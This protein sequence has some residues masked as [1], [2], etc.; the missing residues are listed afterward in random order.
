MT[1]DLITANVQN[2]HKNGNKTEQDEHISLRDFELYIR[3][4]I[5]Q[6]GFYSHQVPSYDEFLDRGIPYILKS[7]FTISQLSIENKLRRTPEDNTIKTIGYTG[8]ITGI[9]INPYVRSAISRDGVEAVNPIEALTR[10]LTLKVALNI[11]MIFT[12]EATLTDGSKKIRTEEMKGLKIGALPIPVFSRYSMLHNC[13]GQLMIGQKWDP[14]DHGCQL[15]INGKEVVFNLSEESVFNDPNL[16]RNNYK[17]ELCRANILSRNG[18]SFENSAETI[19]RH[20]ENGIITIEISIS[21]REIHVPYYTIMRLLGVPTD[22]DIIDHVIQ[23]EPAQ[24]TEI[25]HS[26]VRALQICHE[27]ELSDKY[28]GLDKFRGVELCKTVDEITIFLT[29]LT[30]ILE[31]D[32]QATRYFTNGVMNHIDVWLLPHLGVDEDARPI[33]AVYIGYLVRRMLYAALDIL[34][35]DDR[36]NFKRKRFYACGT[37]MT[38]QFKNL[39][40]KCVVSPAR[41]DITKA[42]NTTSFSDVKIEDIMRRL[43]TSSDLEKKMGQAIQN[44]EFDET[45]GSSGG[46]S[47]N[48]NHLSTEFDTRKSQVF[49]HSINRVARSRRL[50]SNM[51]ERSDLKRRNHPTAAGHICFLTSA[52]TGPKVGNVKHQSITTLISTATSS[53]VLIE[54]VLNN[55]N[56]P[57][58]PILSVPVTAL[59]GRSRIFINGRLIGVCDDSRKFVRH[60]REMRRQRKIDRC[61]TIYWDD[62]T[63]D[64]K[65]WVDFGRTIRPLLIVYVDATT[66]RQYLKYTQSVMKRLMGGQITFEDLLDEGIAEMIS[67]EE[68]INCVIAENFNELHMNRDNPLKRYTHCDVDVACFSLLALGT[69]FMEHSQTQRTTYVTNHFKQT[70]SLP[71]LNWQFR[72]DK[73]MYLQQNHQKPLVSTFMSNTLRMGGRNAIVAFMTYKGQGQEDSCIIKEQ[74]A[75]SGGWRGFYFETF[76]VETGRTEQFGIPPVGASGYKTGQ[77]TK[78]TQSYLPSVGAQI[79]AGDVIVAKFQTITSNS[80]TKYVDTSEVYTRGEPM[81][82]DMILKSDTNEDEHMICKVRMR[83]DRIIGYGDKLSC[84]SGNKTICAH[85]VTAGDMPFTMNGLIPDIIINAQSFVTRL[86]IG[87]QYDLIA[88]KLAAILGSYVSATLLDNLKI[89]SVYSRLLELGYNTGVPIPTGHAARAAWDTYRDKML[90]T[91]GKNLYQITGVETMFDGV[92][93]RRIDTLI[94]IGINWYQR[95][96]KDVLDARHAIHTGPPNIMTRQSVSGRNNMGGL[97]L[98]NME[99]D[100]LVANGASLTIENK[101]FTDKT[102]IYK[103]ICN[104][105]GHEAVGG[106]QAHCKR[107]KQLAVIYAVKTCYTSNTVMNI[108]RSMHYKPV[109]KLTAP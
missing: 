61:A 36:D 17:N 16:Y 93:G 108:I 71:V 45:T 101:F 103:Y 109:Y 97:R 63:D 100:T 88:G 67:S 80:I 48:K 14:T 38:K 7:I 81:I 35:G 87:Q 74:C 94:A 47:N 102:T 66:G 46:L 105:C 13:D 78:I 24:Y 84:T 19:F 54:F 69:P 73:T 18:D 11:D 107:C 23:M 6:Y 4:F 98:G 53:A 55:K 44:A 12:A 75:Q 40:T 85:K 77:Y 28:A 41:R 8:K 90:A 56:M 76:T 104:T 42:F 92:T 39:F 68:Q 5:K 30:S 95:L 10:D 60:Y 79:V 37:S 49:S 57:I 96:E 1:D 20:Y 99:L 52:D 43:M 86:I 27:A 25:E 59:Q 31:K 9:T 50:Q 21:D 106:P 33:K 58:Y 29:K 34:P 26:M 22:K 72:M 3:S 91:D 64:I 70:Y 32:L 83:A 51:T 89:D 15:I 65:M 82:V 2:V 62:L